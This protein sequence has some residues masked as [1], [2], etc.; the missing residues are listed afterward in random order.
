MM[1]NGNFIFYKLNKFKLQ[2]HIFCICSGKNETEKNTNYIKLAW[3]KGGL[4]T[5]FFLLH[6]FRIISFLCAML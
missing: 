5:A 6:Y 3:E 4:K 2:N 1:I